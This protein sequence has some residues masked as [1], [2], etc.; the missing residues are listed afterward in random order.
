MGKSVHIEAVIKG[1]VQG[2]G[3]RWFATRAATRYKVSGYV[4]NLPNGDVRAIIEGEN[5]MVKDFIKELQTGH[6]YAT[7]TAVEINEG[8]YT[9]KYK[10][11]GVNYF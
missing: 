2:V 10:G 6:P 9:G 1:V 11:F 7:V 8:E 5:G 3:Y 4:S